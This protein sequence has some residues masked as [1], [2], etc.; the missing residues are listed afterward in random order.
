MQIGPACYTVAPAQTISVDGRFF[1]Y[2]NNWILAQQQNANP[3]AFAE[4]I[5]TELQGKPMF[6]MEPLSSA[7]FMIVDIRPWATQ[8][9]GSTGAIITVDDVAGQSVRWTPAKARV[10]WYEA[11]GV[12][13]TVDVDINAGISFTVPPTNRVDV[14]LLRPDVRDLA[15]IPVPAFWKEFEARFATTVRC[16]VT[17]TSSPTINEACITR[18][19]FVNNFDPLVGDLVANQ[20][21][22]IPRG[23]KVLNARLSRVPGPG[24]TGTAPY[25]TG[26]IRISFFNTLL[27]LG[28]P[29][30]LESFPITFP[31][32][33]FR[34]AL[35]SPEVNFRVPPLGLQSFETTRARIPADVDTVLVE[36]VDVEDELTAV[37]V[38][39]VFWTDL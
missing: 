33:V 21:V 34:Y 15:S 7:S 9:T 17:C 29:A 23:A 4:T 27:S 37:N 13:Q 35:P 25:V 26:N 18:R 8:W 6:R 39:L 5:I 36:A 22:R 28:G 3:P 1:P 20:L 14:D 2:A 19:V 30:G 11:G 10:T 38:D 12:V 32:D 24:G 16:K 31:V